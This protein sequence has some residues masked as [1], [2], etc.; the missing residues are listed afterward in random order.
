MS[1]CYLLPTITP[2]T[3]APPGARAVTWPFPA[4]TGSEGHREPMASTNEEVAAL[5]RDALR[6]LPSDA[7]EDDI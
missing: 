5:L 6:A 7:T 2:V 1:A 3:E 4:G